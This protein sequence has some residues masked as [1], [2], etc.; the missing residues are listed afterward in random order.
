MFTV[1]G[2]ERVEGLS[3]LELSGVHTALVD[4]AV[5]AIGE[6]A[7]APRARVGALTRVQLDVALWGQMF[8]ITY[9]YV[10]ALWRVLKEGVKEKE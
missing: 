10:Y 4:A 3:N 6:G 5:G 9:T 7:R 2:C 8:I 1:R